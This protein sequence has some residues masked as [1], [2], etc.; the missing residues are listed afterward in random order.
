MDRNTKSSGNFG[1]NTK[2]LGGS[3]YKRKYLH[4]SKYKMFPKGDGDA[5]APIYK[6]K[7][8]KSRKK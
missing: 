8:K 6:K 1:N 7:R 5:K 2:K 4:K 3:E